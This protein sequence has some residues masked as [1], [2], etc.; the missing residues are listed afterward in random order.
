MV[1]V[2]RAP[3]YRES[4]MKRHRRKM[5]ALRGRYGWSHRRGD[6]PTYAAIGNGA[7]WGIGETPA[8]A[9][10]DGR[11]IVGSPHKMKVVI[12]TEAQAEKII[13]SP[14]QIAVAAVGLKRA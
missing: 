9:R 11:K 1:H 6:G 10:R 2:A 14:H 5:R 13:A 4:Q 12:V 7:V 8:S 3:F